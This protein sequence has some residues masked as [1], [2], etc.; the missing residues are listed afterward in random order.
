VGLV[1]GIVVEDQQLT[2]PHHHEFTPRSQWAALRTLQC[3]MESIAD[4]VVGAGVI[5]HGYLRSC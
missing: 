3:E 5:V 2:L 1:L 4:A